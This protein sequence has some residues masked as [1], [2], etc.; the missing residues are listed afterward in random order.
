M[1]EGSVLRF[2]GNSLVTNNTKSTTIE[3]PNKIRNNILSQRKTLRNNQ[4]DAI[5][6]VNFYKN[7]RSNT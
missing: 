3:I 4:S 5:F 2:F 6:E 1:F 7:I